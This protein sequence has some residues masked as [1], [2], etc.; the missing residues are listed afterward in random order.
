MKFCRLI[1]FALFLLATSCFA[2]GS[3]DEYPPAA[4]AAPTF[5]TEHKDFP[6]ITLYYRTT[7]SFCI[8]SLGYLEGKKIPFVKKD[9]EAD[10]RYEKEMKVIYEEKLPDRKV[11]VPLL[12]VGDTALSGFKQSIWENT[13]R[14]KMVDKS[15]K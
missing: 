15:S 14:K 12:L 10:P 13:I 4:P 5:D 11:V 3:P 6:P 8:R 1:I 7:C 9:V 2:D